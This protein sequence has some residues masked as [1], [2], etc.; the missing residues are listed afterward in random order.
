MKLLQCWVVSKY[1]YA[2]KKQ[3]QMQYNTSTQVKI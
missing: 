3:P 2:C 1:V